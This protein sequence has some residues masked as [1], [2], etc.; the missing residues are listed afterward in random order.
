[1]DSVVTTNRIG[2]VL[3]ITLN[4]PKVKRHRQGDVAGALRGIPYPAGRR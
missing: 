1:M 4:R 3:E 2:K